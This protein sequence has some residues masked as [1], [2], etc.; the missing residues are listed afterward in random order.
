MEREKE[1]YAGTDT[2][3]HRHRHAQTRVADECCEVVQVSALRDV[4]P[5]PGSSE[6]ARAR[7][8]R[9]QWPLSAYAAAT[10]YAMSGTDI[11]HRAASRTMSG[12]DSVLPAA[13]CPVPKPAC[14]RCTVTRS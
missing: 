1:R 11:G 9:F 3:R 5:W 14:I 7:W 10:P 8:F 6:R 13:A 4:R 2:H 12:T